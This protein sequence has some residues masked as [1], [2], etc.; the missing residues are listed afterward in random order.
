M[1]EYLTYILW[2]QREQTLPRE[3]ERRRVVAEQ[4]AQQESHSR[5]EQHRHEPAVVPDAPAQAGGE[6]RVSARETDLE[7][8]S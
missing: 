3:L 5:K 1:S 2:R 7:R 8:V 4:L 6:P